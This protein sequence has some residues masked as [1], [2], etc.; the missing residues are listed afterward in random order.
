MQNNKSRS[1]LQMLFISLVTAFVITGCTKEDLSM[2]APGSY[3]L[4]VNAFDADGG[5]LTIETVKEV[6]LYVFDQNK[7]FLG[8]HTDAKPGQF[9]ELNY[10]DHELL[11]V[12]AWGNGMQGHQA[13]PTLTVGDKMEKAFV[14][15]LQSRAAQ[16]TIQ[17][18]D[19]L[20]YGS[21]T[22]T[23]ENLTMENQLPIHRKTSGVA[24][25]ARK[26]RQYAN[27]ADDNFTYVL[28][29]TGDKLNFE[30]K[31]AGEFSCYNPKAS[32]T[33]NKDEFVAPIFNILT[34]TSDIEVDI[35]HGDIRVATI[36]KS[37]D[38]KPLRVEAGRVLNILID[39]SGDISVSVSIT[40]WGVQQI[41][42]EFN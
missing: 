37:P 38:G 5:E 6:S 12:V 36:L 18:P 30:G 29:Q 25:T 19:D 15:L 40:P 8:V 7:Q 42:K 32:F 27:A 14:S 34:T 10:P 13:M 2:C 1:C 33:E 3:K 23:K 24:I 21:V 28:R 17:S 31:E 22:L 26:L 4:I 11:T 39:L 20:F 9:V 41:W 16:A 35:F